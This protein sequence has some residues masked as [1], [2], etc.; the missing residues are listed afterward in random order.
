MA[1]PKDE[2][3]LQPSA[4]SLPKK[5]QEKK[6]LSE[7]KANPTKDTFTP[8]FQAFKPLI[9]AAAYRNMLGSTIPQSAHMMQAAQSFL[10][11]TRTWKPDKGQFNTHA[12]Q[13]VMQKG[14]RLNLTYQNIG[15]IPEERGT[16]YQLF[17]NTI[18]L[19]KEQLGREPSNHEIA[20]ELAWPVKK[21]ETMRQEV[22]SS[23]LMSES[24]YNPVST[25]SNRVL[26]AA[27]D[28]MYSLIPQHQLVLQHQM[29]LDGKQSYTK[30]GGGTDI[31]ALSRATNLTPAQI[32]SAMKTISRKLKD[33]LGYAPL[34]ETE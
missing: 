2:L 23:Y 10:D 7:F 28:V 32:R 27:R 21:V 15:Y 1:D 24:D 6:L 14:K 13:T 19:L 3:K 25:R 22:Q 29:G 4:L 17:N 9:Y 33:Y 12:Y 16:K 30:R 26:Q 8:L 11:A 34:P 20:D 18:T 31:A 5:E